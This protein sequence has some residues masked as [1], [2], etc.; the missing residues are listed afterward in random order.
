MTAKKNCQRLKRRARS[1]CSARA[2]GILW[3]SEN[4]LDGVTKHLLRN[5]ETHVV[6]LWRSRAE[7]REY[8]TE[9]WGYI[10][11]RPD[12]RSEPHGW[13]MPKA[14]R[15]IILPVSQNAAGQ[16]CEA[17]PGTAS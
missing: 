13:R 1:A 11:N 16:G 2:W 6:G 5:E 3:H 7:A 17:Y 9:H 10:R 14:V 15:V 12:L 4:R 8:A